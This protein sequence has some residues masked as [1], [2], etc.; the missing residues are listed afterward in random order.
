MIPIIKE[1]HQLKYFMAI[2]DHFP[3]LN[4]VS[5]LKRNKIERT[6]SKLAA[7]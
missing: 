7:N 5:L 2:E 6:T 4:D 3:E 1:S